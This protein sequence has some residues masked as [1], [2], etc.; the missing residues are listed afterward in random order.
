M[1]L[2]TVRGLAASALMRAAARVHPQTVADVYRIPPL[3]PKWR[4][5]VED[6]LRFRQ[7][8]RVAKW[9]PYLYRWGPAPRCSLHD[10]PYPCEY[11]E[12]G[13]PF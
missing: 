10:G 1:K 2:D 7:A 6:R 9:P 3:S 13:I 11:C 8:V 4:A 12:A 5:A